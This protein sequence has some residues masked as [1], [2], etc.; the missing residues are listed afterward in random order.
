[1]ILAY[2][3]RI[4]RSGAVYLIPLLM[5][6]QPKMATLKTLFE[7]SE[8]PASDDDARRLLMPGV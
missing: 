2:V 6:H 8:K 4:G 5:M 7:I 1:M 3:T